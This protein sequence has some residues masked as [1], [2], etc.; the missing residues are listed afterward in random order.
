MTIFSPGDDNGG[1]EAD[2]GPRYFGS[3]GSDWIA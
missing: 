1:T 3:M 2:P